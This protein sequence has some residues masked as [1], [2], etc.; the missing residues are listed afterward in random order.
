M[1]S[2]N[3]IVFLA[4]AVCVAQQMRNNSSMFYC[5]VIQGEICKGDSVQI[6]DENKQCIVEQK[7]SSIQHSKFPDKVKK[8]DNEEDIVYLVFYHI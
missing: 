6:L 3:D 7:I 1:N 8:G 4:E 5:Q 2:E